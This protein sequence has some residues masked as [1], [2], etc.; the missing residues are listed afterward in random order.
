MGS[1]IVICYNLAST[2]ILCPSHSSSAVPVNQ[3]FMDHIIRN[4]SVLFIHRAGCMMP[5]KVK[6]AGLQFAL[7]A[8]TTV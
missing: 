4:R 3:H 2:L 5:I 1:I 7:G 6:L 8:R